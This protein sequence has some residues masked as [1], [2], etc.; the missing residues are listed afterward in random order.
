MLVTAVDPERVAAIVR[1]VDPERVRA[2]VAHTEHTMKTLESTSE[3]LARGVSEGR[4]DLEDVTHDVRAL[5]ERGSTVLE[6]VDGASVELSRLVVGA[7]TLL[8]A[9]ED[10]IRVTIGNIRRI[11]QD[12]RAL[13]RAL[14]TQPSLLLRSTPPKERKLP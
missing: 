6:H 8:N 2:I 10:D 11:S 12:A 5:A 1:A 9:N 4:A 13:A 3:A 14:R 7:T